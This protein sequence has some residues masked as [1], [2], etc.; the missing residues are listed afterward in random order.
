MRNPL[1]GIMGYTQLVQGMAATI[2]P[3]KIREL[4]GKALNG[5][6]EMGE[7]LTRFSTLLKADRGELDGVREPFDVVEAVAQCVNDLSIRFDRSALAVDDRLGGK[8]LNIVSNR[9]LFGKMTTSLLYYAIMTAEKGDPVRV[10]V[11]KD[12]PRGAVDIE[13]RVAPLAGTL[14]ELERRGWRSL[15]ADRSS[16]NPDPGFLCS[17][18]HRAAAELGIA[19][20][21][22]AGE[23]GKGTLSML[24]PGE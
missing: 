8:G 2:A 21:A 19:L 16:R 1:T 24:L 18:S 17:F 4:T 9:D 5:C 20:R 23:G 14:A 22:T 10:A 3:A 7:I 15:C 13:G 12:G 6:W 11:R